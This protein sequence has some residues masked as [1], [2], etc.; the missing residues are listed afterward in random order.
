MR[1]QIEQIERLLERQTDQKERDLA[2]RYASLLLA[3]QSVLGEF[4]RRY[5]T[6][7]R[8]TYVEVIRY[9]RLKRLNNEIIELI[10]EEDKSVRREIFG[11]LENQYQEAFYRVAHAIETIAKAKLNYSAVRR[12]VL[13]EAVN[14]D[15][16][17]LTL[18]ERLEKRRQELIYSMREAIVRGL[19]QG[20]TYRQMANDIK[21]ELEGDLAKAQRIVRTEAHRVREL[22]GLKSVQHAAKQGIVMTKTWNTVEDERV[23]VRHSKLNG[24]TLPHDGLFRIDGYEAPAPGQFGAPEMDINCRCFL[25]YEIKEITKPQYSELANM[26]YDEWLKERLSA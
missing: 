23:R 22:A 24:V 5:E 1:K 18:N 15:F 8:L 21:D 4:Y 2:K 13:D 10:N 12:E 6:D 14:I 19:H 3:I 20:K 16:T 25:T 11:H 17:G 9:D 7:G 26:S